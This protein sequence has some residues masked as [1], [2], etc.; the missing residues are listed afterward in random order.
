MG[1]FFFS[2]SE[3][4]SPAWRDQSST[5]GMA[6]ERLKETFEGE[7]RFDGSGLARGN[8]RDPFST[9]ALPSES[10]FG[11]GRDGFS[12]IFSNESSYYRSSPSTLNGLHSRGEEADQLNS[13]SSTLEAHGTRGVFEGDH[14][15]WSGLNSRFQDL[16]LQRTPSVFEEYSFPSSGDRNSILS[17][18]SR[19]DRL[20]DGSSPFNREDREYYNA[21]ARTDPSRSETSEGTFAGN[22]SLASSVWDNNFGYPGAPSPGHEPFRSN[23]PMKAS[24]YDQYRR[25][26]PVGAMSSGFPPQGVPNV[27]PAAYSPFPQAMP[28]GPHDP[29]VETEQ[30]GKRRA[31]S[32]P[33]HQRSTSVDSYLPTGNFSLPPR[34]HDPHA[35]YY[36]SVYSGYMV[37]NPPSYENNMNYPPNPGSGC[38]FFVSGFCERGDQCHYDHIL[39][40]DAARYR[41]EAES[42][43]AANYNEMNNRRGRRSRMAEKKNTAVS[44]E[45]SRYQTLDQVVGHVYSLCKDQH[46][47]RFLQRK[48]DE[49]SNEAV[50]IIFDEVYDHMVDLMTDPFGNYLC[51]K[52]MEHCDETRRLLIVQK[53]APRL[54]EISKNVHGTRAVQKMIEC[55]CTPSQVQLVINSLQSHVVSLIRDLNGNH[56]IQRC[57]YRLSSQDKQFIYDAVGQNCVEVGTHRHG[58]CVMQRCIDSAS[59]PQKMQLITHI[60]K[61]ALDLVKDQFGNYVV[62]YVLDLNYPIVRE[63]LIK[64]FC[65]HIASLSTQKF[66][67]NVIEKCLEVA[68]LSVESLIIEEIMQQA[69]LSQLLQDP[70]GNYVIQTALN[71]ASQKQFR[72]FVEEI[73]PLLPALR[74]TPYGKRIQN[75]ISRADYHHEV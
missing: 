59:E 9:S 27:P 54:I 51:Q 40:P 34:M 64:E 24:P 68:T 65:G 58:C 11:F 10:L 19:G 13:S 22:G 73:K 16:N 41:K 63:D 75:K 35:G 25:T 21:Q 32:S 71:V 20:S 17:P 12:P 14:Q 44:S 33:S 62:Q 70:Y 48:L 69:N 52:L 36:P 29:R 5:Y 7:E 23:A 55:L 2:L 3:S 45:V 39:G 43:T 15:L 46:G 53:V 67:S 37:S 6:Q 28:M 50:G 26:S 61:N 4:L 31:P 74:N 49:N 57:L 42:R 18:R 8:E 60:S 38:H 30:F 72:G 56:V 47:C 1:P 66:S